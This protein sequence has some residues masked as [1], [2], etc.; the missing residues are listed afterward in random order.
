MPTLKGVSW[1]VWDKSFQY[2][3]KA[4]TVILAASIL[5]WAIT[6]FPR[7]PQG[8]PPEQALSSSAAGW[9]GKVIEPAVKPL[10]FDWKI[11]IA[12]VTGFAAKET[13][14]ST[15]GILYKVGDKASEDDQSLQS[16]LRS[17][18]VFSPLVAYTLMLFTL[19]LAPCFAAQATIR[20][21]LGTGWLLFYVLFS[22]VVSWTLC[23]GVY[24]IGTLLK[25]GG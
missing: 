22:I 5:I 4:G 11:G 19:I 6:T 24:Q 14:V 25:I 16:A 13:V 17:D 8:T 23:F 12:T 2:F 10:G 15:L 3:K 20:A 21:E 18:P 7:A 1:H 9:V